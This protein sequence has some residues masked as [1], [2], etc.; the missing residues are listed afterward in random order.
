MNTTTSN[1]QGTDTYI[2]TWAMNPVHLVYFKTTETRIKN[3]DTL[4]FTSS[5]SHNRT[6]SNRSVTNVIIYEIKITVSTK[7]YNILMCRSAF[8]N[9]F[10]APIQ[11]SLRV[12]SS[13]MWLCS[14]VSEERT[15]S[16]SMCEK[17]NQANTVRLTFLTLKEKEIYTFETSVYLYQTA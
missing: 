15:A 17:H 3:K 10:H 2:D 14:D 4:Q 16:I 6:I 1:K 12:L 7:Y 5:V 11:V 13:R 9:P 8:L